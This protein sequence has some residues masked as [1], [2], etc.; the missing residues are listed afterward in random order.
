MI[1]KI[2]LALTAPHTHAKYT[3]LVYYMQLLMPLRNI[4]MNARQK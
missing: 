2:L 4:L 3:V 1:D